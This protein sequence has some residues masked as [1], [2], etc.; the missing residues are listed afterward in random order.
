MTVT[1]T[2]STSVPK[3]SPSRCATTSAWWMAATT[4]ASS[5]ADSNRPSAR[6]S[7]RPQLE[8]N[9]NAAS[10]GTATLHGGRP[11]MRSQGGRVRATGMGGGHPF[12]LVER[13]RTLGW[14]NP[15]GGAAGRVSRCC[16]SDT[17]ISGRRRCPSASTLSATVMRSYAARTVANASSMRAPAG[18]IYLHVRFVPGYATCKADKPCRRQ[19]GRPHSNTPLPIRM[20]SR[21]PIGRRGTQAV[22]HSQT[23]WHLSSRSSSCLQARS[24]HRLLSS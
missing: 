20:S 19:H 13:P 18:Q 9:I 5:V 21:V 23:Q 15:E 17:W 8:A 14:A 2:A 1:A 10:S 6:P 12:M 3:G 11:G 4:A 22:L 24:S 7:G 16:R